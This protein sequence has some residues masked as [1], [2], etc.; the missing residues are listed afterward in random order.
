[1]AKAAAAMAFMVLAPIIGDATGGIGSTRTYDDKHIGGDSS[2]PIA[3]PFAGKTQQGG[4][5]EPSGGGGTFIII[6]SSALSISLC[7][8]LMM[9]MMMMMM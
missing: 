4:G 9:M 7:L 1:M 8:S 5:T 2:T 3:N 6:I